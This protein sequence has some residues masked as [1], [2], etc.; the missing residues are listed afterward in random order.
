MKHCEY[1]KE[2]QWH[3]MLSLWFQEQREPA[4]TSDANTSFA[5]LNSK[6]N[7]EVGRSSLVTLM[8]SIVCTECLTRP[9]IS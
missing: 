8:N 4:K 3:Q 9:D 7:I 6:E 5:T 1:Q 2:Q